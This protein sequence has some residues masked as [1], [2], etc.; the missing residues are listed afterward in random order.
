MVGALAL[1]CALLALLPASAAMPEEVQGSTQH[2]APG[3]PPDPARSLIIAKAP[4]EPAQKYHWLFKDSPGK[5]TG[6]D[7]D[8]TSAFEGLDREIKEARRLYL[9]GETENA[10]LK[11]RSAIDH[12]EALLDDIPA[13]H[14]ML[15]E[16]EQRLSLYDELATKILGP[17]SQEPKEEQAGIIFHLMEKRRICKRNLV[18]RKAGEIAF[19]DVPWS[20][21]QEESSLLQ[22]LMQLGEEPD[23]RSKK[24]REELKAKLAEV[25][26][27]L[28]KSSQRYARLR[29]GIPV[30]LAEVRRDLLHPDEVILDFN[31]FSDRMLVGIITTDKATYHQVP[32][33]R[34]D[35][36][37]GVFQLQERLREFATGERATFMGHAWKEQCRRTFRTLFGQL[38]P[39]PDDKRTV[40][41]IPDRSLWYLPVSALLD[42]EDRPIG[43]TRLVSLIPSADMLS[44]VRSLPADARAGASARGLLLFE[45]IPWIPEEELKTEDGPARA[46]KQAAEKL[47][48]E[49]R[50]ER[51]ILTNPVYPKPSDIA[52]QL[53]KIFKK[54]SIWTAQAATI[55]RFAEQVGSKGEVGVWAVPLAMT[56]AISADRQPTLF[57]S[58]DKQGQRSLPVGSLFSTPLASRMLILPVS[59]VDV[60]D[61]EGSAGEGPLLLA[62]AILY[63]GVKTG[64]ISYSDPNWGAEAP[65]LES[66]LKM[67]AQ[68]STPGKALAEY[69]RELPS[70]LDTSFTGK[71]PAWASWIIMGD[72]R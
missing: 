62:T 71:P 33:N 32:I 41:V 20:S 45:S 5:E 25:R 51:L 30:S 69:T 38:P 13:G 65:F 58:P 47:T 8:R 16:G 27:S 15:K 24:E 63:A 59:W 22:K 60:Q 10:V 23:S 70:A 39:L 3:Q 11:Y 37:K 66:V 6:P 44:F 26:K 12:L 2:F 49:E 31:I 4:A 18:L 61:K 50:I 17:V 28:Q 54:A 14:G 21:V 55:D 52:L 53:Q 9:A 48:E 34:A 19:F 72:P 56:D 67:V 68:G 35:I 1:A 57:F 36:D 64:M 29:R 7:A 46:K 40:F 43:G 42:P